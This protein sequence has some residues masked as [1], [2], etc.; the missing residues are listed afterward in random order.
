MILF[1]KLKLKE[2]N[3]QPASAILVNSEEVAAVVD[4]P[5]GVIISLKNASQVVVNESFQTVKNR[6]ETAVG[7]I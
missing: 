3:G 7:V 6:L 2:A 1:I 4:A 5:D